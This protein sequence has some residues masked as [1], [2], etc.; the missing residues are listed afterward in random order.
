MREQ[1]SSVRSRTTIFATF[2][3]AVALVLGAVAIVVLQRR[4]LLD[5]VDGNV[6]TRA[7]DVAALA[8]TGA[9]PETLNAVK[10]EDVFTQIVD[11]SGSVLSASGNLAG[12]QPITTRRPPSGGTGVFT[13]TVRAL[14]GEFRIAARQVRSGSTVLYV[15]SG[16]SLKDINDTTH[17]LGVALAAGLPF[18]L[19][20]VATTTWVVAGRAL[21]PVERIR[22]Q[23]E[24]IGDEELARRVP[25]PSTRD[26]IARLAVTMNAML[27]RLEG[28]SLRQRRFVSDAA[29]ELQSPIATLRTRLE[30]D[31]SQPPDAVWP[32]VGVDALEEVI[33]MQRL[34]DD[35]LELAR[36]DADTALTR[37][38]PVDV[39]DLALREAERLRTRGRVTVD[40]HAISA[41]QVVGDPH[42][43]RRALRNLLDNAE[44]HA[45]H[46][47]VVSVYETADAVELTVTDDGPGIPPEERERVFE[48]FTRLDNHRA[49]DS[50]GT[51][52]GLTITR[53]LVRAHHGDI[54]ITVDG[55]G[56]H[57]AIRLPRSLA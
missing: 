43:L 47:V 26:E 49:R 45:A 21:R 41:G 25:E 39:D 1:L 55:R 15:Y 2:V 37:H 50:G 36:L 13:G 53:E 11:S 4:S 35:L 24:A 23:V 10:E 18:L 51:G 54:T 29:H 46:T 34:I 32:I 28:A 3:V 17:V 16:A 8:R 5:G 22:A 48:P 19:A 31:L 6:S 9:L 20:L 57:F 38:E 52:L 42:Q 14:G 7:G 27:T 12:E 44:R 40:T 56:T 33:A 30:V